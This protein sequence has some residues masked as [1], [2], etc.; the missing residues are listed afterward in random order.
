MLT[1]MHNGIPG[2]AFQNTLLNR[3]MVKKKLMK[4]IP[5]KSPSFTLSCL[6]QA[7]MM[8]YCKGLRGLNTNRYS[9]IPPIQANHSLSSFHSTPRQWAEQPSFLYFP[10]LLLLYV[11]LYHTRNALY[12][13]LSPIRLRL[14]ERNVSHSWISSQ[15][16]AWSLAYK[17]QSVN[18]QW[19]YKSPI[20]LLLISKFNI[21]IQVEI[22]P[23]LYCNSYQ[24]LCFYGI[25]NNYL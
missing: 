21:G 24:T 23:S 17:K 14:T 10:L 2:Y 1:C 5:G 20:I 22:F 9:S 7:T 3:N 6:L 11:S 19:N 12:I 25:D 18:G 15:D 4:P 16:L 8:G 13:S